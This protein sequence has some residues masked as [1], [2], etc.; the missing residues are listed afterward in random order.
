VIDVSRE[1][2]HFYVQ[3]TGQQRLE[4]FASSPREFFLKA[5]DAQITFDVNDQGRATGLVLH[6]NG[7]DRSAKRVE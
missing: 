3:L 7:R 5:V 6:Q 2:E 1:G 4:L